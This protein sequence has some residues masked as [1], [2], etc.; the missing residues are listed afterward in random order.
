MIQEHL[1]GINPCYI[2]FRL[3]TKGPNGVEWVLLCY[4]PDKAKVKDKMIYAATRSTLKLQLGSQFF[5]EDIFGT[6]PSD[7]TKDGFE[8]HVRARKSDAPLT[9][10]EL[11]KRSQVYIETDLRVLHFVFRSY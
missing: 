5:A 9:E 2:L 10:S 8:A 3:D 7:F 4:V 1:D 6:V 11:L